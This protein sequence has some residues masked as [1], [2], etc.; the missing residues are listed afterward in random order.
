MPISTTAGRT[1]A[2]VLDE[3]KGKKNHNVCRS[4]FC[5]NL[6]SQLELTAQMIVGFLQNG[7]WGKAYNK[8]TKLRTLIQFKEEACPISPTQIKIKVKKK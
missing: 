1:L 8:T 3:S 7:E 5:S 6:D 4:H 2:D